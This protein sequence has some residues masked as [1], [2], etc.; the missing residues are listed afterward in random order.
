MDGQHHSHVTSVDRG[1]AGAA[2]GLDNITVYYQHALSQKIQ[3]HGTAQATTD[4]PAN[5]LRAPALDMGSRR[6]SMG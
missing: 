4:Q 5:L 2:I 3:A 6:P 1:C